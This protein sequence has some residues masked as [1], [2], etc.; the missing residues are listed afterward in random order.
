M[1]QRTHALAIAA[2]LAAGVALAAVPVVRHLSQPAPATTPVAGMHSAGATLPPRIEALEVVPARQLSPGAQ[3]AFKLQGSAGA[4][5]VVHLP[6][7]AATLALKEVSPGNYRGVYL[8]GTGDNLRANSPVFA[9]LTLGER[10][11]SA[12]LDAPLLLTRAAASSPAHSNSAG[13]HKLAGV[14]PAARPVV[15][16]AACA[17]CVTVLQVRPLQV[18]GESTGLGGVTGGVLGAVIG[19]QVGGGDGRKIAG[20]AGAVGGAL[21]G[22]QIEKSMRSHTE[23][24]VLVQR[25]D[26]SRQAFRYRELPALRVGDSARINGGSLVAAGA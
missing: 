11:D 22:T 13:Q 10:K 17:D 15:V 1:I 8:V 24:E 2:A 25:A 9:E 14:P 23:Y 12:T 16:T 18:K 4:Q 26:G 19:S 3:L 6:D 7:A 21:A 5:A 20:V